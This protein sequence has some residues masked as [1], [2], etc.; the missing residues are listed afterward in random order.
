MKL[1]KI[2]NRHQIRALEDGQFA[3]KNL[4]SEADLAVAGPNILGEN[5]PVLF[6][7]DPGIGKTFTIKQS[8]KK[9][10]VDYIQASAANSLFGLAI[11]LAN[12]KYNY[13][14]ERVVVLLD[15]VQKYFKGDGIDIIKRLFED[16]IFDYSVATNFG[17][18]PE[19]QREAVEHFQNTNGLG[20]TVD[21]STFQFIV[22]ANMILPDMLKTKYLLDKN[23]GIESPKISSCRDQAAIRDR[24]SS[25]D[26]E[27]SIDESWGNIAEVLLNCNGCSQYNISLEDKLIIINW[28][29][30]HKGDVRN[31]TL[32]TAEKMAEKMINHPL[33]ADYEGMWWAEHLQQ[34]GYG[35]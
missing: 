31:L 1:E 2:F 29:W 30:F 25:H 10:N 5:R 28:L 9:H 17:T 33:K 15:D 22:T 3:R 11:L 24:C 20:F 27:W 19:L 8:L 4:I 6:M 32:R 16:K 7:G 23:D 12:L 35:K 21:C 18:I 26:F 13:K 34:K 14:E